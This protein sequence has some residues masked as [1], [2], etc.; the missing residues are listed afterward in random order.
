MARSDST[1]L[2]IRS[3]FARRSP[4][5]VF[6]WS[7]TDAWATLESVAAATRWVGL[8]PAQT[9]DTVRAFAPDGNIG[10]RLYDRLIGQ[11]AVQFAIQR[12]ITWNIGRMR[13]RF[14]ALEIVDP[15]TAL[16]S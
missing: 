15:E 4:H 14:P 8:A 13:A 11:V 12:I 3:R 10:P 1:Q 6:Q 9:F 5:S 2:D 7:A 16:R